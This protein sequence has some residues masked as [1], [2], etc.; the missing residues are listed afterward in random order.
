MTEKI[1]IYGAGGHSKTVISMLRSLGKW[2]IAG[3]IDDGVEKGTLVSGVPVL[4]TSQILPDLKKDGLSNIVNTVGGIGNYRI[5]WAIFNMLRHYEF[6]FPTIVH[7]T[8]FVEDNA[9]LA[10]GVQVC[11]QSYIS[12]ESKVG[13]GT[14]I[15]AG[16]ILSH[17]CQIGQC[18]NLSP[19]AILAGNV[20]IGDFTQ[21]GMGATINLG[22]TVGT[23]CRIGNSAVIKGD[24][25][26]MARIYAGSVWPTVPS[27]AS[28]SGADLKKI[29]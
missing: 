4:G 6:N 8:A 7:P 23:E 13:F 17:E 16:V 22:I 25:P 3:I 26:D 21:I 19:G 28:N 1:L 9:V 11:A 20:T 27:P 14:L 12:S 10:D 24:V 15:N 2:E 29:A 18:V 5:R